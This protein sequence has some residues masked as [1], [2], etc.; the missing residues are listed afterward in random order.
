MFL[1]NISIQPYHTFGIDEKTS[2]FI[3]VNSLEQLKQAILENPSDNYMF[4]GEGSNV[5]FTKPYEGLIIQNKIKGITKEKE[6]DNYV[7]LKFYSGENWHES[8]IYCLENNYYGIENL[9]LIP[10]TIG[11]APMQNIG[12]YGVEL[13]SVFYSLEALN[14]QTFELEVFNKEKCLFGYRE[15]VFKREKKGQYFIFSVTLKLFKNFTPNIQ[16]GDIQ[17]VLSSNNIENPTAKEV[18]NA[19]IEIRQSKLPNPKELGNS[20]SFFKNPTID[21]NLFE[22]LKKTYSDI[23]GFENE[24]GIKIPAAWLIEKSGFKGKQFGNVGSH[25]KQ[26]LV[27]VNYGNAKGEEVKNLSELIIQKVFEEFK[28]K[29]EPEV[30]IY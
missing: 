18:S 24:K 4:L 20:G 9:S 28:I 3:S 2:F 23:K 27:L 17:A 29:L 10:G 13:E 14:L 19:V 21:K 8:V 11:A 5:L 16:Y 12:A 30:N 6:D 26:A 1:D 22:E 7:Y 25:S 15:S